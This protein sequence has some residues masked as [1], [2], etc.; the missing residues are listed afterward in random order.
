[1]LDRG[2]LNQTITVKTVER[3]E[4]YDVTHEQ[5]REVKCRIEFKNK[6][7]INKQ[8]NTVT[9]SATIFTN[10]SEIDAKNLIN[11]ENI[12]YNIIDIQKIVNLDGKLEFLQIYI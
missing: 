8:G 3:N 5:S 7:V 1:M 2:L 6:L 9:A 10:D 4:Y 12:D 11:I